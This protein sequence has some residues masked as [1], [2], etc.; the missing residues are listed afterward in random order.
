M[1]PPPRRLE[2]KPTPDLL[3]THSIS[4]PM[5]PHRIGIIGGSGLYS[6]EG[7]TRQ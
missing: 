2:P 6:I 1:F 5:T 3:F 7:F 4:F